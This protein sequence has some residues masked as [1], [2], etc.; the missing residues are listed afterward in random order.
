MSP[1]LDYLLDRFG[2]MSLAKAL[3]LDI[4]FSTA[5]VIALPLRKL[6]NFGLAKVG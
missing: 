4:L 5:F 3:E 6:R 2:T 1:P